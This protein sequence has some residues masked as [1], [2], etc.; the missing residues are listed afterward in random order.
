[1]FTALTLF[2]EDSKTPLE[3]AIENDHIRY[4]ST[5]NNGAHHFD[6]H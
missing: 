1:M 3:L 2:D 5:T 4:V 6:L